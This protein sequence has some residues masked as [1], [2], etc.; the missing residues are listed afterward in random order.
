[1]RC[2]LHGSFSISKKSTSLRFTTMAQH[3]VDVANAAATGAVA[4]MGRGIVA[5]CG[6]STT[7]WVVLHGSCMSVRHHELDIFG[8]KDMI[9]S[10]KIISAQNRLDHDEMIRSSLPLFFQKQFD[11]NNVY[12]STVSYVWAIV[13][14]NCYNYL[15][16][17]SKKQNYQSSARI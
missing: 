6:A 11:S 14:S 13:I 2:S 3:E 15:T 12:Q 8:Y 17:L 10:I 9:W 7:W 4:A 5:A 1:M 16:F